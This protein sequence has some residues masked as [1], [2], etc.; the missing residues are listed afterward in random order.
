MVLA[1][2]LTPDL[3]YNTYHWHEGW[4]GRSIPS[5]ET[6]GPDYSQDF[7]VYAVRWEP[8]LIEWY[9]D[10]EKRATL[11]DANVSWEDMYLL[12]NLAVGGWWPGDPD[13]ATDFPASY[14]IDYI[15][16]WQR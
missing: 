9:V 8:G 5:I 16:A 1:P 4:N 10:G 14:T 15:R 7:H 3:I 2:G 11:P 12:V 13:S 6:Y